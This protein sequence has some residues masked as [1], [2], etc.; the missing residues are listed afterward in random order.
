[1]NPDCLRPYWHPVAGVSELAPGPVGVRLL[2][3]DLVLWSNG[4]GDRGGQVHAARDLCVHRGSRLSLGWV[5]PAGC[6]VCPYHG[7]RYDGSGMCV[8]IPSQPVD[9]Q[10]IPP[11]ARTQHYRAVARYGLVWVALDDPVEDIPAFPEFDDPEFHTFCVG[12]FEWKAGAD[13]F[14]EN[15]IDVAHLPFVH[16]GLLGDPARPVIAP[17][18]IRDE[19]NGY[20]FANERHDVDASQFGTK[21][22]LIRRETW[23]R[24][25]FS[26]RILITSAKGR[27]ATFLGVQPVSADEC[28]F[29]PLVSRTY[30]LDVP[31]KEFG[32]FDVKV[33][34]QDRVIVENQRPEM[35]PLDLTAELHVKVADAA[36]IEYRRRLREI[37]AT[38][39][40][41]THGRT[42]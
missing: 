38:G 29:W 37:A 35:L 40:E 5:D 20:W 32:D 16:P 22:E 19:G 30:A 21:G 11:K 33:I 9:D 34:E 4:D 42:D 28:R 15:A 39:G 31:D 13:R 18:E 12:R 8:F 36:S 3:E 41:G 6:I 24:M 23:V 27:A 26:W 10:R 25:P 17:Y 14:L 2:D 1:M 7:W